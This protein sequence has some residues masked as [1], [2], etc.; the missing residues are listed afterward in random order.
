VPDATLQIIS[1]AN[2]GEDRLVS[3]G[4]ATGR[5]LVFSFDLLRR[6]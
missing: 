3:F 1:H 2:R 5:I 6:H 4:M